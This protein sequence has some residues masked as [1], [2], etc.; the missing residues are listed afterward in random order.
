MELRAAV[1]VHGNQVP[2]AGMPASFAAAAVMPLLAMV[3]QA[4]TCDILSGCRDGISLPAGKDIRLPPGLAHVASD[5]AVSTPEPGACTS[6]TPLY[7]SPTP[8]KVIT[9]ACVTS[10]SSQ[11]IVGPEHPA[12]C[13]AV[14][15]DSLLAVL[16]LRVAALLWAVRDVVALATVGS[17]LLDAVG[18]T[19]L[20][21]GR[22]L[23]RGGGG[24]GRLPDCCRRLLLGLV[25]AVLVDS[26]Q[27]MPVAWFFRTVVCPGWMGVV[28]EGLI[29][30]KAMYCSGSV[31]PA[32]VAIDGRSA[33]WSFS[34][35]RSRGPAPRGRCRGSAA[36]VHTGC[37]SSHT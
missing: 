30:L 26:L 7:E 32:A 11:I 6:G 15:D 22:G 8:V 23:G 19:L 17:M 25:V 37:S 28:S 10:G 20:G 5:E 3:R 2:S 4:T 13:L 18:L 14:A 21:R 27:Y 33:R 24:W 9:T 1:Q 29:G 16:L 34:R 35:I 31:S 36:P 12:A